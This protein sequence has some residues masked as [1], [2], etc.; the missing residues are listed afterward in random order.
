[1]ELGLGTKLERMY[2]GI[3]DG[4][5]VEKEKGRVEGM[6]PEFGLDWYL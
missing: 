4:D 1:M 2:L 3:G 5:G 6:G